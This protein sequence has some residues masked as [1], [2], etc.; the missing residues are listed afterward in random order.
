[1]RTSKSRITGQIV[2][3]Q[4]VLTIM[5]WR[6]TFHGLPLRL[7][8]EK[9]GA[10][11]RVTLNRPEKLNAMDFPDQGGILDDSILRWEMP[12]TMTKLR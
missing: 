4:R 12:K 11:V 1:M 10:V 6:L 7:L 5:Q 3:D 9:E 8:Y 2:S